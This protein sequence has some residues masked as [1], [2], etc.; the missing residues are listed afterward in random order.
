[1]KR[2]FVVYGVDRRGSLYELG[3][4]E[5]AIAAQE[6][7]DAARGTWRRSAVHQAQSELTIAQLETLAA[8]ELASSS[9]VPFRR[10][11]DTP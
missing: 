5:S 6:M 10:P 8:I 2:T 9:V 11:L 4:T 1:M 7:R 3:R